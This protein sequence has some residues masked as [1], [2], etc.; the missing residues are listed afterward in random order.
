MFIGM[1][2]LSG[3]FCEGPL[4]V[5]FVF[6]V[7]R[8]VVCVVVRL[9]VGVVFLVLVFVFCVCRFL[10]FVVA[11][12]AFVWIIISTFTAH[13]VSCKGWGPSFTTELSFVQKQSI[14][15]SKRHFPKKQTVPLSLEA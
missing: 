1:D 15:Q 11:S 8:F 3:C 10:L 6:L 13:E 2:Y 4:L 14:P 9:L 12:A 7:W 5:A